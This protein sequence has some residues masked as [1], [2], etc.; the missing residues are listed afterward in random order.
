[1]RAKDPGNLHKKI[2]IRHIAFTILTGSIILFSGIGFLSLAEVSPLL[3]VSL[4]IVA[5]AM[6]GWIYS[7]Y[8]PGYRDVLSLAHHQNQS[9]E[10]SAELIEGIGDSTNLLTRLQGLKAQKAFAQFDYSYAFPKKY[11]FL[12]VLVVMTF[13]GTIYTSSIITKSHSQ[14]PMNQSTQEVD[15]LIVDEAT[16]DNPELEMRIYPPGYTHI[17]SSIIAGLRSVEVVQGSVISW[18]AKGTA[19]YDKAY[20]LFSDL[21]TILI[22]DDQNYTRRMQSSDYFKLGLIT[23]EEMYESDIYSIEVIPDEKPEVAI[24]GIEEYTRLD[25]GRHH[26]IDFSMRISDDYGLSEASI[27]ATVAKGSGEAV[28]FRERIFDIPSFIPGKRTFEGKFQ[29]STEALNMQPGD[30][31]YFYVRA[32]DNCSF[33]AQW[34]KSLTHFVLIQDTTAM[35]TSFAS[36]MQV[37]IMPEFF[38][39]QRQIIIDSER[40]LAERSSISKDSFNRASN[41][42]G[43]DI[44]LSS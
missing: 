8:R 21:D 42:L 33:E 7:T 10:F 38:R 41:A 12:N 14:Q 40:L 3:L 13:L 22:S 37:D 19:S 34:S 26:L 28:K 25:F 15:G 39:S 23:S 27:S 11:V 2:S 29:F 4:G 18:E 35:T 31:L 6:V 5:F 30:E 44:T 20:L 32:R 9:L 36:G 24:V 1:M 16:P 43:Y 17:S